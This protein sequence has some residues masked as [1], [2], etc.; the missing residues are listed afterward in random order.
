MCKRIALGLFVLAAVVLPRTDAHAGCTTIGGIPYCSSLIAGSGDSTALVTAPVIAGTTQ[1]NNDGCPAVTTFQG[2]ICDPYDCECLGTC[3]GGGGFAARIGIQQVSANI[4]LQLAGTVPT[5]STPQCDATL[6]ST[7]AL[8]GAAVCV[9]A[10]GTTLVKRNVITPGPLVIESPGF[11]QSDFA[12]NAAD[13]R[14]QLDVVH[15]QQLCDP[16]N[17]ETFRFFAAKKA[18]YTTCVFADCLEQFCEV[19]L[20]DI[21]DVNDSNVL[22]YNCKP[23]KK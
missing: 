22:V 23:I 16:A 8:E 10:D 6:G 13:F 1:P 12:T 21:K 17:G 20:G 4:F 2:P 14:F 18:F 3:E 11:G 15:Q 9:A 7:C 19:G 5:L